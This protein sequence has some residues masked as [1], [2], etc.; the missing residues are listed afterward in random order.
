M[1]DDSGAVVTAQ[2]ITDSLGCYDIPQI[3]RDRYYLMQSLEGFDFKLI[4]DKKLNKPIVLA[5]VDFYDYA[6]KNGLLVKSLEE[7]KETYPAVYIENF[8]E[9]LDFI[10]NV[11]DD[12][13]KIFSR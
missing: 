9:L 2:A 4:Y 7:Y 13:E 1:L 3:H 12:K 11:K 6:S 5:V 8:D 10:F